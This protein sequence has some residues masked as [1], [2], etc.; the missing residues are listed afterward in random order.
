LHVYAVTERSR[1]PLKLGERLLQSL[2][3]A[4]R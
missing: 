4:A 3:E 1:P 2:R